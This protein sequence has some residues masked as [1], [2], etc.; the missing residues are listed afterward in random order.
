MA[1]SEEEIQAYVTVPAKP[2]QDMIDSALGE[3]YGY[4]EGKSGREAILA[5]WDAM[6]LEYRTAEGVR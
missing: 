2:T 3:I 5:V 4:P 1:A 6:I